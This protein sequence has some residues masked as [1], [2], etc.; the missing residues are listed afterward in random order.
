MD[1]MCRHFF[2][3]PQ[4]TFL[5]HFAQLVRSCWRDAR[6][7]QES[8][9]QYHS[10]MLHLQREAAAYYDNTVTALPEL[11]ARLLFVAGLPTEIQS[12]V[13]TQKAI[14]WD[15]P[16]LDGQSL[17][18]LYDMIFTEYELREKRCESLTPQ[19]R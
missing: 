15:D 6:A 2:R 5:L 14:R 18:K 12:I 3:E 9:L 11:T 10:R 8:L 16:D 17:E 7:P 19:Q 1:L 13:T 4:N